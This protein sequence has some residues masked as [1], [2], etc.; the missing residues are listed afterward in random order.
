MPVA[1]MPKR[2]LQA[3]VAAEDQRF[4][5]HPGIDFIGVDARRDRQPHQSRQAAGRRLGHHP[6]GRQELP[7]QQPGHARPQ[8]PRGD[9][10]LPIEQT[11]S[12]ER[13]LEL[14]LNE[15][16]LGSGN[17]G[18]AAAALNY[19]DTLARQA[20]LSEIAYLAAL[21]KAPNRYNIV[22]QR[23]GANARRD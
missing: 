22:A 18:V 12:K 14:Y 4:F 2:V 10:R 3:F 21:P 9:P 6:A 5:T 23:E 7:A 20:D 8:D 16:Y 13:I 15:I 1:A 11:Y 19:F 17:Y